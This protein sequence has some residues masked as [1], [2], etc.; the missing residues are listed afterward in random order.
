LRAAEGSGRR[1]LC[2]PQLYL[3]FQDLPQGRRLPPGRLQSNIVSSASR[4]YAIAF[5]QAPG[6]PDAS[7]AYLRKSGCA[8]SCLRL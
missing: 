8:A 2:H 3:R 5:S 1:H 6:P 7:P 4:L